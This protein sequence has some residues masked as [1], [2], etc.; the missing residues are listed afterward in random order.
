[1][2]K[3]PIIIFTA[4]AFIIWFA[5]GFGGYYGYNYLKNQAILD[6]EAMDVV[7]LSKEGMP[8]GSLTSDNM[9]LF[10]L[11]EIL[12][13]DLELSKYR[14]DWHYNQLSQ[15]EKNIYKIYEYAL[16]NG[17]TNIFFEDSILEEI[18]YTEDDILQLYA[19]DSPLLEQ[20]LIRATADFDIQ[21]YN[22][23]LIFGHMQT[24]VNGFYIYIENFA[25]ADLEKKKEAVLAVE[26]LVNEMPQNLDDY[27]KCE[28]LYKILGER[29]EYYK[30]EDEKEIILYDGVVNNKARCDGM[31]NIYSLALNLADVEC[32]EVMYTPEDPEAEGH[33]WNIVKIG[34][35]YCHIDLTEY[36]VSLDV[37]GE[38]MFL[39]IGFSDELVVFETD[40]KEFAPECHKNMCDFDVECTSFTSSEISK[41]AKN[42]DKSKGYCLIKSKNAVSDS[43]FQR[44][45][46]KLNRDIT[47][48]TYKVKDYYIYGVLIR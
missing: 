37:K 24:T 32:F 12:A 20:N 10:D 11:E 19:L 44:F 34:E 42:I 15:K 5:L 13:S 16:E 31:A 8:D 17:Y 14:S 4:L 48:I 28:Y 45:C 25:L 46:D 43:S 39:R 33:T 35:D 26:D 38:K 41:A 40:Y 18:S 22:R 3:K 30:F 36:S 6:F 2:K 21:N 23:H 1:M 27:E 47:Y 29:I 9:E 7:G